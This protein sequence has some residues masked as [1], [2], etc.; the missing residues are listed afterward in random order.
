MYDDDLQIYHSGDVSE[1]GNLDLQNY[2]EVCS[3]FLS[4]LKN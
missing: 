1:A 3:E 2:E 4:G